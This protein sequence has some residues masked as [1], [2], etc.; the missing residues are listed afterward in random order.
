MIWMACSVTQAAVSPAK[1]LEMGPS[2]LSNGE[3]R[4]REKGPYC[5]GVVR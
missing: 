3:S 1:S 4:Q 5:C 2:P